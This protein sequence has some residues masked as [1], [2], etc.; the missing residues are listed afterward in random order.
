MVVLWMLHV[1][2]DACETHKSVETVHLMCC[3]QLNFCAAFS[4]GHTQQPLAQPPATVY[5]QGVEVGAGCSSR[6]SLPLPAVN[7]LLSASMISSM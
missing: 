2:Q 6:T 7:S 3:V 5:L 4:T 1:G